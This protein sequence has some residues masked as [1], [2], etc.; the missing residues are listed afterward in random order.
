MHTPYPF[1][2]WKVR[3]T[4]CQQ[5]TALYP[6]KFA[7]QTEETKKPSSL[8]GFFIIPPLPPYDTIRV[9]ETFSSLKKAPF[10]VSAQKAGALL[11][12]RN[13]GSLKRV[14]LVHTSVHVWEGH[15]HSLARLNK[16]DD[17]IPRAASYLYHPTSMVHMQIVYHKAVWLLSPYMHLPHAF[18][19]LKTFLHFCSIF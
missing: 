9:K 4:Y 7:M 13:K 10:Y 1:S 5:H 3:E 15:R 17:K 2:C 16:Y 8:F 12:V 19:T 6:I 18:C 11:D 14:M